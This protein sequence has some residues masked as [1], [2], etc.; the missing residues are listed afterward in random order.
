MDGQSDPKYDVGD[1][2]GGGECEAAL[3]TLYH[4][5]DGELTP[6]RR[7]AIQR[8][9]DECSPCLEAFDFEAEL[10]VLVARCC[11]DQVP[12]SLRIKVAEV[13]A[14]ASEHEQG[15]V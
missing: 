5:L 4:Y 3:R 7:R 13:L 2:M 10:K 6:E 11:R 9:L 15:T 12:E 8:H 1:L 14:K